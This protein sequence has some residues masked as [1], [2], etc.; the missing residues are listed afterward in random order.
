MLRFFYFCFF[1]L[2]ITGGAACTQTAPKGESGVEQARSSDSGA[3]SET[4]AENP[5]PADSAAAD[6]G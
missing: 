6:A 5:N 2:I 4:A 1:A 3:T